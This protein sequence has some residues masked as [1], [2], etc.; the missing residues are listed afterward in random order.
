MIVLRDPA[1]LAAPDAHASSAELIDRLKLPLQQRFADL[2][3]GQIYDPDQ[4]GYL[5]LVETGDHVATL[6]QDTGCP[7]LTDWRGQHRYGDPDFSPACEW[8][9]EYPLYYEM[10]YVL[11][12]SGAALL[13]I[14]P[15]LTG[16]ATDLLSLCGDHAEPVPA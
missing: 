1:Q 11:N 9:S 13:L 12:D 3:G 5:V 4:H 15:K 8:L 6:E 10:G 16:I 2:A 14:I 7:I